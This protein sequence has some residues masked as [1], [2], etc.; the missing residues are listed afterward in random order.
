MINFIKRNKVLSLFILLS[1]LAFISGVL[2]YAALDSNSKE[3]VLNNIN[4]LFNGKLINIKDYVFNHMFLCSSI[5][6]L[7]ISII[8]FLIIIYLYLF[9]VFIFSFEFISLL[10]NVNLKTI[11]K[12]IVYLMPNLLSC[13]SLFILCY[14]A[15]NYSL[16]LFKFI[17]RKQ[18]SNINIVTKK[19]FKIFVITLIFNILICIIEFFVLKYI[20]LLKI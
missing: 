10:V 6:L 12:T 17:F 18:G 7:G 9:K 11:L 1:I 20:Y 19:Y 2:F 8:G 16:Y 14:Y 5:W 15:T 4:L 3:L 13:I